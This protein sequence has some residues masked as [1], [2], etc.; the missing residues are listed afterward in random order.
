MKLKVKPNANQ[1]FKAFEIEARQLNL[2]QRTELNDKLMDQ[3]VPQNLT[4]WI[5]II[6]ENTTYSDDELNEYSLDELVAMASAIIESANK[7]KLKK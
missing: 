2:Q 6:K 4:F 3:S 5:G 1:D 7:K